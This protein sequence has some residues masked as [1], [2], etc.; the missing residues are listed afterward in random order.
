MTKIKI[1]P[2]DI[3]DTEKVTEVLFAA[4]EQDPLMR[5]FFGN[6]YQNLARY[7]MQ[8]VC[9]LGDLSDLLLWGAFIEEELTGVALITP[10]EVDDRNRQEMTQAEEQLAIA[11]GEAVIARIERYFQVKEVNK[12]KQPHFY[13]DVLGVLPKSQG[14]GVG[15]ALIEKLHKISEEYTLSYG[16]ALDTENER[17]LDFYRRLGYLVSTTTDLD[18]VK[19]WSMF[20][21]NAI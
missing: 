5:Y 8:Y 21:P 19:V 6:E 9:K 10:P 15:K 13:L 4:F 17:N 20:R 12:P 2:L 16:I 1:V 14:Q 11:V 3:K 7:L 18:E